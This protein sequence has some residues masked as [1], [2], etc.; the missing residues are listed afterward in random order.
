[1]NA[2]PLNECFSTFQGEGVHAGR[3]AFF[4]RLQGCPLRCPWC[5]SASTWHKDYIPKDIKRVEV[6]SLVEAA[7]QSGADICVI[8]GGEPCIHDLEDLTR[9]LR[10][11]GIK[12]HLETSG[13]FPITGTWDWITVSPKDTT[14]SG[15]PCLVDNLLMADELKLIVDDLNVPNTWRARFVELEDRP[16][17]VQT[18]NVWL[19]P[20]WSKHNDPLLLTAIAEAVKGHPDVFRAGWQLH[21]LY[22]VDQAD[23]RSRPAVPLGGNPELGL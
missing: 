8:T 13:A 21:K 19:H 11:V 18:G 15:K 4:I 23:N 9:Q 1:M 12:T 6:P 5:D 10:F 3:A 14:V 22:R 20:E 16:K 2:L 17:A 7:L